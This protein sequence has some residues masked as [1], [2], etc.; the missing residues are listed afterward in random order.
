MGILVATLTAFGCSSHEQPPV[1]V[2]TTSM[3]QHAVRELLPEKSGVRIVRIIPPGSCPGHFDCPPA[4]VPD[5]QKARLVICHDF[6]ESLHQKIAGLKRKET[7]LLFAKTPGSLL[8][9]RNYLALVRATAEHLVR[10]FPEQRGI[11]LSGVGDVERR[12]AGLAEKLLSEATTRPWKGARVIASKHQ[13]QFCTWLGLRVTRALRRPEDLSPR[14]WEA[15][16]A[17]EAEVV[18]A[19]LQEGLLA[20]RRIADE[21]KLPL[22]VFSNFTCVEGYGVTYEDLLRGNMKF[23]DEAWA[24]R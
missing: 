16:Q 6:Q 18:I 7:T 22:A 21:R 11:I 4:V 9:P 17:A 10:V 19:N 5:L 8:I 23:L 12:T 3:L 20:A 1:V 14:D 13:Q 15:L 24:K 2:V